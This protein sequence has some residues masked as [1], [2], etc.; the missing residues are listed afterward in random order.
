MKRPS[1][2]QS[3]ASRTQQERCYA[4]AK[5]I[6]RH[7]ELN[8]E[9]ID[10]LSKRQKQF[11]FQM[12]FDLPAVR[13]EK[14]KTIPR[15]FLDI[16][17]QTLIQYMKEHYLGNPENKLTYMDFATYGMSF[18]TSLKR[19]GKIE[20]IGVTPQQTEAVQ[21]MTT[22]LIQ[23]E[24]D[25]L[26]N[27]FGEAFNFLL[28]LTRS[29][30]QVNFRLYGFKY[31]WE[32]IGMNMRMKIEL[33]SQNCESKMFTHNGVKRQ[34]FRLCNTRDGV[35]DSE[36]A[37]VKRSKIFP[38][39]NIFSKLKESE[40]LNIYIQSHVLHRFKERV[41]IFE[42]PARNLLLHF[43]LTVHQQVVVSDK[44]IFLPC[45]LDGFP[46]GYFTFF[47]QDDDIVLNT[48]IPL[49]SDITPEGK[50]LQ[51]LLPLGKEDTIYLGMDK[52]SFFVKIDFEQ[53]P[54]LKQALMDSDI[55]KTKEALDKTTLKSSIQN[56]E[57]PVDMNKT[58]FVKKFFDKMIEA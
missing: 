27:S 49:V 8:P 34:A 20:W 18:L 38:R 45:F 52:L 16:I 19:Y 40:N 44:H 12:I 24:E 51:K 42:A 46:I 7:F 55:W 53:I 9:L 54:I 6:L 58:M 3:I 29:Y 4:V 11:L 36:W 33:T 50:K 39:N 43:S 35:C 47:V 26:D 17:R 56:G 15:R 14:E 23:A 57:S 25:F 1:A 21:K 28:Y 10:V 41:D 30:S 5:K 2:I 31:K 22:V 48:F 37:V 32:L 13:A